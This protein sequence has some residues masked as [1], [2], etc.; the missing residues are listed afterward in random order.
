MPEVLIDAGEGPEHGRRLPLVDAL[1][2]LRDGGLARV[3][4]RL[5]PLQLGQ[6]LGKV[7]V[8]L[9]GLAVHVLECLE[10]T[11]HIRKVPDKLRLRHLLALL[12]VSHLRREALQTRIHLGPPLRLR[13]DLRRELIRADTELRGLLLGSLLLRGQL[14]ALALGLALLAPEALR[15]GARGL[16]AVRGLAVLALEARS[17]QRCFLCALLGLVPRAVRSLQLE[18]VQALAQV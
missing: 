7:L 10:F 1:H 9:Q 14:L 13:G 2:G 15:L 12:D 4:L 5:P 18:P 11:S 3:D 17:Q 8:L 16:G 6:L